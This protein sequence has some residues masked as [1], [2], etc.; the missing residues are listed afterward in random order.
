MSALLDL[1]ALLPILPSYVA[2]F[3]IDI[4]DIFRFELSG[5]FCL[6]MSRKYPRNPFI[7]QFLFIYL[8]AE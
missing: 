2:P 8:T 6:V 7:R 3:L 5:L 1:I 4:F